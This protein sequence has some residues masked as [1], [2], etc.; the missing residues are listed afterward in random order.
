[1]L[2]ADTSHT[3]YQVTTPKST[4]VSTSQTVVFLQC[5]SSVTSAG[6]FKTVFDIPTC[7]TSVTSDGIF[8]TGIHT[9]ETSVTSDG[10][11]KT[12]VHM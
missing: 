9:C 8:K 7:E 3:L 4:I 10:I 1:M 11:L 6:I 12:G 5:V 2:T